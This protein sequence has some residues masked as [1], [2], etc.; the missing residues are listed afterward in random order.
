[1]TTLWPWIIMS[2]GI[3]ALF[4]YRFVANW[5]RS[6]DIVKALFRPAITG[7]EERGIKRN[8]SVAREG[9][10]DIRPQA[11]SFDRY[12]MP[13]VISLLVLLAALYVILSNDSYG[14]AQQKWASGVVGTILGYWFKR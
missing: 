9:A 1:M 11:L 7:A 3:V 8:Q 2:C 14:D 5:Q 4:G 12:W 13:A 10:H 6:L